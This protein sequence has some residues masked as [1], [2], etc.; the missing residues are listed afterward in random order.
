MTRTSGAKSN[1]QDAKGHQGQIKSIVSKLRRLKPISHSQTL[2]TFDKSVVLRQSSLWPRAVAGTIMGVTSLIVLWACLAKVEEAVS[3]QGKLEP[4]GVV[5]PVQA[6]LNGVVEN[7]YI[8]EGEQVNVGDVLITFNQV[9]ALAQFESRSQIRDKLVQEN[10]FYRAQ[11]EGT[12]DD[13][14]GVP[15][16]LSPELVQLT[17]YRAA[18]AEDIQLYQAMLQGNQPVESLSLAQQQRFRTSLAE[19]N[20]RLS[21]SALEVEQLERQLTQTQQQLSNAHRNLRVNQD[22]LNRLKPLVERGGFSE[23]Q[24]LQQEQ[25]VSNRQTEVNTLLEEEERL[26][27]AISQAQEQ[28]SNTALISNEELL[29]RI[30]ANN[31]EIANIDSQLTKIILEN[32]KQIQQIEGELSQIQQTL[33]YQKLRAPVGGTVFNLKANKP[34]YVAN[35]SEPILEIVPED[36]LVAR[37]FITNQD[38]GFVKKEMRVDVRIDSF[39]YSEFGDIEGTL[40]HIGSDAL[41]PDE[42][43]PFYRFPAE[44]ELDTQYLPLGEQPLLL[45]S[46]MSVSANI[47]V[48][49]RR[50]ITLL[51]NLFIRK[52]DSLKSGR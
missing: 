46:G 4:S 1:L 12:D 28:F 15:F 48:R 39:S 51:S 37:V 33:T 40:I 16:Q 47:K 42:T 52:I 29:E 41:P 2:K 7:I 9:E 13:N 14:P 5:Q 25:E 32:E 34:G 36:N 35:T 44:I 23:I 45:Q 11:L 6:P 50:V 30:A 43:F 3:A 22:I 24:Y 8:E 27:V 18:L 49:K 17:S 10:G 21:I 26:M 31:N 19:L 38:I 20:S